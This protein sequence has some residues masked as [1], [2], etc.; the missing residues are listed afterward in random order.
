MGYYS[1]KFKLSFSLD[2]ITAHG[3]PVDRKR[4]DALRLYL[5]SEEVR[6]TGAIQQLVPDE[7]RPL[8]RKT[9]YK[10]L[11][12]NL[13]AA[14]KERGL[15]IPKT[16]LDYYIT[17]HYDICTQLDYVVIPHE[18]AALDGLYKS[19]PFNP[20]SND[21]LLAYIQWQVDRDT[22]G[23][24]YVPK[25]IKTGKPTV[26]KDELARLVEATNDEALKLTQHVRKCT[27]FRTRY[28][29]GAWV[30][31]DDG[32]VHGTF[33]FGTATQ[34]ISCSDPNTQQFLQHYDPH[35]EFVKNIAERLKACIRAEPG[36][37]IVN[38]DMCG[39][40]ARMQGFLAEDADYYRLS[41]FDM[42][43][44]NTAQFVG[45]PLKDQLRQMN[46]AELQAALKSIKKEH[47]HE[48]DAYVKRVS[49]LNQFGG[50]AERA[51]QILD[52][53]LS[54]VARVLESITDPFPKVFDEFWDRVDRQIHKHPRIISP[55][56]CVRW[57]WDL[58]LKEAVAYTVSNPAHCH[59]QD[60]LIRL[61]ETGAFAKYGCC[62][63]THDALWYHC[64]EDL[65]SECIAV[66]KEEFEKP[67]EVLINSLGA[68]HCPA[69]SKIGD[70]LVEME[71]V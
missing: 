44:F 63:F 40:H 31:G 9:P 8:N 50:K 47:Q 54:L 60:A 14:L 56:K 29:A 30:P 4:Q 55:H 38:V 5:E 12:K 68:F 36:Y 66:T 21:Q 28:T 20:N 58:D 51:S 26:G 34:Q 35:D 41:S 6:L 23:H 13:R 52:L 10:S 19:L 64:R 65:V 49:F 70:S 48:R 22:T 71:D 37:K 69:D 11:P 33:R 53:D 59:I 32:R 7:V 43:T 61:F 2:A 24:W 1:H 18:D 62:N 25:H 39:F 42:H 57:F 45:H 17:N 15:L 46:D 16:P 3:L 27:T 67:S